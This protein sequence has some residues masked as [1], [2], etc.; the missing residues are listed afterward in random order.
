[1]ESTHARHMVLIDQM[2]AWQ[3]ANPGKPWTHAAP[4][5]GVSVMWLRMMASTDSYRARYA[6]VSDTVIREVGLLGLKEKIAAAA[7]LAVERLAEKVAVSESLSD[8]K[9][10]AEMLLDRHYG[11]GGEAQAPKHLTINQ[12]I[13]LEAKEQITRGANAVV[14][15][16][17]PAPTQEGEGNG[18]ESG[19]GESPVR[20]EAGGE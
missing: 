16:P 9:D 4:A 2:I 15:L 8:I 17:A 19:S 7:E 20:G 13:I 3:V 6:E 12:Q 18:A 5:L 10:A 14:V 11:G 1:M